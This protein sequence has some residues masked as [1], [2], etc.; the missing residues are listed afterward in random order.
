MKAF[1]SLKCA[2]AIM[3]FS[4]VCVA[5]PGKNTEAAQ[6]IDEASIKLVTQVESAKAAL[7]QSA[8]A[9]VKILAEQIIENNMAATKKLAE[10]ADQK[11]LNVQSEAEIAEKAKKSLIAPTQ[12][13]SFDREYVEGQ[14]AASQEAIE[15]FNAAAV[16]K[17][18]E[19]AGFA[20]GMIPKLKHDLHY[21]EQ[22]VIELNKK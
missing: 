8:S 9:D 17:D 3:F 7:Q 22:L 16:S 19:L 4:V 6:F 21:A 11:N 10:I 5:A 15:F 14:V 20:T 2:L 1:I 18:V 12:S 13:T